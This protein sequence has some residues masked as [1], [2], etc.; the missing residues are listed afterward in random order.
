[1]DFLSRIDSTSSKASYELSNQLSFTFKNDTLCKVYL[2]LFSK[3]DSLYSH[4]YFSKNG[5]IPSFQK[6]SNEQLDEVIKHR[7]N[8][9]QKASF[10]TSVK[11]IQIGVISSI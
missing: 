7:K 1:K 5:L 10:I 9:I 3:I 11:K 4:L 6:A 2:N 8:E